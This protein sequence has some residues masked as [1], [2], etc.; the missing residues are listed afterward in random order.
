[1]ERHSDCVLDV[2]NRSIKIDGPAN[3]GVTPQILMV[4]AHTSVLRAL[5][6]REWRM[7]EMQKESRVLLMAVTPLSFGPQQVIPGWGPFIPLASSS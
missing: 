6:I 7:V 5:L 1:M 2:A 3:A 4:V